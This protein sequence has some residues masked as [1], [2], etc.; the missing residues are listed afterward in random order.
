MDPSERVKEAVDGMNEAIAG[1]RRV[2]TYED[3][4]RAVAA[5]LRAEAELAEA[6]LGVRGGRTWAAPAVAP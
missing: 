5:Y 6:D 1:L 2:A 4:A 3:A